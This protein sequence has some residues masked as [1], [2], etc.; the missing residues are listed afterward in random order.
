MAG[1]NKGL[2]KGFDVL[3]PTEF[4]TSLL[5]DSSE[6]IQKLL[7]SSISPNPDQPRKHFDDQAIAELAASLKQFGVLQPLIVSPNSDGTY[8]IIAGERRWRAAQVAG[9][10][11]VPT[12]VRERKELEEL[13]IA[14]I[15]NVQRVDLSPL[16]QA[17]S[18]ERL[19]QQFNMSYKQIAERLSKAETTLSNLV[20]LLQ[21]PEG[22][23]DAL[24]AGKISEGHARAILALKT[25]PEKQEE[26]LDTIVKNSWS[27]RQ[28]EQFVVS[29][30]QG[31]ITK[32]AVK[33][34]M[35]TETPETKRIGERLHAPVSIKRTA[36]GGR[37]EIGFKS[38][39]ELQRL[40]D[41]LGE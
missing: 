31:V 24:Q 7:V 38:D 1:M 6:R 9:L 13:E 41:V 16:E 20:R 23:R 30:K 18:I 32:T 19:H 15:E 39:E 40:L 26:L 10:K 12:I 28:A 3:I 14:L 5:V 2:G 29:C 33:E 17:I 34:R 25:M 8:R 35:A 11:E 22:A 4:D 21:L 37:V 27:V 36:K